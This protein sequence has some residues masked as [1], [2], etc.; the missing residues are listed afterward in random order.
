[1]ALALIVGFPAV[2]DS[3]P[4]VL[5]WAAAILRVVLLAVLLL[6]GLAALYRYAPDRDKPKWSWASP[7][8]REAHAADHVAEARAPT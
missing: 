6:A 1:M 3:W 2:P 4:M 7:G 5:Q 8:E